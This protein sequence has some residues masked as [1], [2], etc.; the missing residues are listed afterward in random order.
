[1]GGCGGTALCR[2]L[3]ASAAFYDVVLAPLGGKRLM[4][5]GEVIGYG[6]AGPSF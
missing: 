1:V 3:V 5:F 6:T 4:D 2:D